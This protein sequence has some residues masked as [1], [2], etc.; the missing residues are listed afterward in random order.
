MNLSF[1]RFVDRSTYTV[2]DRPELTLVG[3]IKVESGTPNGA[4]TIANLY[5]LW[6]NDLPQ[7]RIIR[8][9]IEGDAPI[10]AARELLQGTANN[11]NGWATAQTCGVGR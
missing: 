10:S 4:A 11:A 7:L 8:F 1:E 9:E 6:V 2:G 5:I 3:E